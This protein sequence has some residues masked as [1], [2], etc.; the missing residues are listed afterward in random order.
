M[1]M[2]GGSRRAGP[3][4][5]ISVRAFEWTAARVATLR[6]STLPWSD[7]FVDKVEVAAT[8]LRDAQNIGARDR[9]SLVGQFAAHAAFLQFGGIADGDFSIDEWAIVPKRGSDCR[10]I[11][12]AARAF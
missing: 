8:A 6:H 5:A 1:A 9:L 11:R 3:A 10:L 12:V 2:R 4:A 7:P